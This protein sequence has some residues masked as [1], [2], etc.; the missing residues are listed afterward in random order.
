MLD[1][2]YCEFAISFICFFFSAITSESCSGD[3]AFRLILQ[4]YIVRGEQTQDA[5]KGNYPVTTGDNSSMMFCD[6]FWE[7]AETPSFKIELLSFFLFQNLENCRKSLGR[8][9]VTGQNVKKEN[10][11]KR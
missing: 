11:T 1:I 7:T 9:W 10:A 2:F 4:V 5:N 3:F 8:G 6:L